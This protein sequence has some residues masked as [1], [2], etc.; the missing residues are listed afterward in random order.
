MGDSV[1]SFFS[2]L[3]E[4]TFGRLFKEVIV[5]CFLLP[6]GPLA[7]DYELTFEFDK[8][9]EGLESGALIRPKL[10]VF[11]GRDDIDLELLSHRLRKEFTKQFE[12]AKEA[13][14][15]VV[16]GDAHV[17]FKELDDAHK[18][19]IK[20]GAEAVST[21]AVGVAGIFLMTN[22]ITSSL[23][24]LMAVFG[25]RN[26]VKVVF[27]RL[28]TLARVQTMMSDTGRELREIEREF[29]GKD[30]AF[31]RAV[32][33]L[34]IHKHP[35]LVHLVNTICEA[36]GISQRFEADEGVNFPSIDELAIPSTEKA[37]D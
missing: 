8:A 4:A 17:E 3:S 21:A 9:I 31:S 32:S 25:G 14:R 28:K 37:I 11:A 30:S 26:A 22:P 29:E 5:P 7:N 33:N 10:N 27:G 35:Y 18:A 6:T 34:E 23:F 15:R 2:S 36:G 19:T 24:L 16:A 20:E 1:S 13:R 12:A